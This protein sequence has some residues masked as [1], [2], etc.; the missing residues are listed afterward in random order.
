MCILGVSLYFSQKWYVLPAKKNQNRGFFEQTQNHTTTKRQKKHKSTKENTTSKLTTNTT[1]VQGS[2]NEICN[3]FFVTLWLKF[4]WVKSFDFFPTI[5]SRKNTNLK[6]ENERE[7]L[8]T[9]IF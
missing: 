6:G 2:I 5:L 7:K 3:F 1:D 9:I 8:T 4:G